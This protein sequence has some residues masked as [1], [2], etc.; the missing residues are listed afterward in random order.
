M[1]N[2]TTEADRVE[3]IRKLN[4]VARSNPSVACR[5]NITIGFQSL[6]DADKIGALSQ[7]I[8]FANFTGEN[9]PH[10][11]QDFGTVYRLAS[12]EW[13]QHRPQDDKEISE[14]VFWKID[15]YDPGLVKIPLNGSFC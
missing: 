14:T 7:I 5:A 12:G 1:T 9:D 8:G 10:G 11:E 13:I 4:A 6:S 15:L 3:A 2:D